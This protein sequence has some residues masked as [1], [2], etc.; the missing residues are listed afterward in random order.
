MKTTKGDRNYRIS[1][2]NDI[3]EVRQTLNFPEEVYIVDST[4][5]SLQSGAS[6]GH[7]TARDL[8][9][10]GIA[11]DA[12]GVRELIVNLTWKY[13]I[14]VCEGLAKAN[15]RCKLVGVVPFY[16]PVWQKVIDQGAMAGVDEICVSSAANG[17]QIE[18]AAELCHKNGKG[19]SHEFAKLY[20]YPQ[21]IDLCKKGIR[22]GYQS[23]SFHDSFSLF[24]F[25]ITPEGIKYFISSLRRDIP[26]MPPI[27]VHFSNLFGHATMVAVAALA[28]G[29]NAPDV[30][31]N[32][33]GHHSGHTPL[34]EVV[35]VLECLY[36]VNTGIN[37]KCLRDV[38][39]LVQERSGIPVPISKPITGDYA[40]LIDGHF[41]A[42]EANLPEEQKYHALFPFLPAQ[43]GSQERVIWSDKQILPQSIRWKLSSMELPFDDQ[44]VD[45]ILNRMGEILREKPFYPNWL[46]DAEFEE[47]CREVVL[48][49]SPSP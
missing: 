28:A 13:G 45:R 7:C 44:H 33:I 19:I 24:R 16:N 4:I 9:D 11:L 21:V 43:V 22:C 38:S 31:M 36:G 34:E 23:Q 32:G 35:A 8:V 46:T 42:N 2:Y 49:H 30:S 48:D 20:S 29:A 41:R 1:E 40:F 10:I 12:L 18:L 14:E 6:G 5:R 17:E 3:P 25:A 27:H 15:L 47:I 37:L 26:G 39:R